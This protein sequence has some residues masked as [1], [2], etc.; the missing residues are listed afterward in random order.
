MNANETTLNSPKSQCIKRY[1]L[2]V[3]VWPSSRSLSSHRTTSNKGPKHDM[4]SQQCKTIQT[5]KPTVY[6]LYKKMRNEKHI[7]QWLFMSKQRWF[8]LDAFFI[9]ML[10]ITIQMLRKKVSICFSQVSRCFAQVLYVSHKYLD[11][12]H[13]YLDSSCKY[14][15][16]CFVVLKY[17]DGRKLQ[18]LKSK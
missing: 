11:A 7:Y 3:K 6:N 14:I 13:K 15:S 4:Q 1:Q 17:L 9:Q 8:H 10:R 18:I 12:S 16:R 5:G 2:K